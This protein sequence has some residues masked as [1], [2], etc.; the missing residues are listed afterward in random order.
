MR[1]EIVRK[2]ESN[3]PIIARSGEVMYGA[4][5]VIWSLENIP[6]KVKAVVVS[7]NPPPN[8]LE[9]LNEIV[10]KKGLRIPIIFSSK[11]NMELAD[12][13][14][15]PHSVSALCIL[16]FGNAAISEEDLYE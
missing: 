15:R 2:L 3:I 5:Y 1:A 10:N 16:D 14:G 11:T 9:R 13:C 6:D 8:F 4:N 12:L 7:R